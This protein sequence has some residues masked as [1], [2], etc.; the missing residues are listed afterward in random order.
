MHNESFLIKCNDLSD[1]HSS[2]EGVSRS[3]ILNRWNSRWL[4]P[5]FATHL[6]NL[7]HRVDIDSMLMKMNTTK[8]V[9]R[10]SLTY[11]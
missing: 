2:S 6:K 3:Y 5:D 11:T 10:V 1:D 4:Y 8:Q 9:K 7:V